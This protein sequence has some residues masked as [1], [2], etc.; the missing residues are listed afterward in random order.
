WGRLHTDP[1]RLP[2]AW[3]LRQSRLCCRLHTVPADQERWLQSEK[4][5]D[6]PEIEL[7][8][9]S[10]PR[11]QPVLAE[12]LFPQAMSIHDA[13]AYLYRE[14]EEL[15][16]QAHAPS[17]RWLERP[18]QIVLRL[19]PDELP[20]ARPVSLEYGIRELVG[21]RP[22]DGPATGEQPAPWQTCCLE[23]DCSSG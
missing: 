17:L 2:Y 6:R 1:R 19:A 13:K 10:V 21:A 8:I 22:V 12:V 9:L 5:A 20:D 4:V 23:F 14:L 3:V 15:T 18:A 11:T 7:R 16:V